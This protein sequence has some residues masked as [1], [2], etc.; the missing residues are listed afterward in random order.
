MALSGDTAAMRLCLD[1]IMPARKD[2]IVSF[3]LP[4]LATAADAVDATAALVKAVASGELTPSEAAELSK[5]V[6]AFT[7][8][9]D[10]HE[11]QQRLKKLEAAQEGRR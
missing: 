5:L 11:I 1:R 2:R 7:R 9:V 3:A 4:K 10:L 8:A 6:E